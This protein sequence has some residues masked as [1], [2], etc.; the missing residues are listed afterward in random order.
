MGSGVSGE[1]FQL[2]VSNGS[3]LS[4][5][6][7]NL[8]G[9]VVI[10][11]VGPTVAVNTATVGLDTSYSY[12]FTNLSGTGDVFIPILSPSGLV[13]VPNGDTL[14][15]DTSTILAD[16]PGT[17]N[18]IP[19]TDGLFYDPAA[20]LEIPETGSTLSVSFLDTN[21]AINGPILADGQLLDPPVPGAGASAVPEPTSLA[22]LATAVAG[23]GVIRRRRERIVI[24]TKLV[25]GTE[26]V[27]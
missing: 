17:G 5:Q 4:N 7:S 26:V 8:T 15:T 20:L 12:T 24:T 21:P 2:N 1:G 14:I 13:S 18:T 22:L 19:G 23:F 6:F 27:G 11:S 9:T 16:W 3:Y 10:A 25:T